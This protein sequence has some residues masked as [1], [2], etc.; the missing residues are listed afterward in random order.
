MHRG[1][2]VIH[3]G[4]ADEPGFASLLHLAVGVEHRAEHVVAG[5]RVGNLA[6]G[7]GEPVMDVEN[8]HGVPPQT[9]QADVHGAANRAGYVVHFIGPQAHLGG[10]NDRFGPTLQRLAQRLLGL[11]VAVGRGHVEEGDAEVEG[12]VNGGDGLLFGG[13]SPDLTDAAAS[14]SGAGDGQAG[15]SKLRV[16]HG[17]LCSVGA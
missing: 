7:C 6:S 11:A 12:A 13:G 3:G 4:K 10:D 9:A 1:H 5:Q 14:E 8:I 16:F 2:M 17:W 15:A